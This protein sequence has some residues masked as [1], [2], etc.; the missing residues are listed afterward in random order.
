MGASNC[1]SKKSG[2]FYAE[3]SNIETRKDFATHQC[4]LWMSKS[5]CSDSNLL[6][7]L[8]TLILE[9]FEW[10]KNVS[11]KTLKAYSF[12]DQTTFDHFKHETWFRLESV[13]VQKRWIWVQAFKALSGDV[14]VHAKKVPTQKSKFCCAGVWFFMLRQKLEAFRNHTDNQ[15][16][17]PVL[18]FYTSLLWGLL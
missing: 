15:N 14:C 16:V 7:M 6:L 9:K 12:E 8:E 11:D 13:L 2:C 3:R 5:N 17:T 10:E 4:L 18:S 1:K